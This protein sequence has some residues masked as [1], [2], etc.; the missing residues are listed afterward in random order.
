MLR[1]TVVIVLGVAMAL[2]LSASAD[3]R[4]IIE[5]GPE[6]QDAQKL[7][8]S[9]V[10]RA[11]KLAKDKH[12]DEAAAVLERVARTW[13]ASVHDCNLALAYLRQKAL[14][15]AQLVWDLAALRNGARPKWCTGE[16][17]TQL[18]EAL[19]KEG[20]VPTT[21][22]VVPTDAV[23]EINGIAMRSMRTV[24][25]KPGPAT[26]NATAPGRLAKTVDVTIAAPVAKVTITLEEPQAPPPDAGVP[27]LAPVDAAPMILP[28][29][30][31]PPDAATAVPIETPLTS[32]SLININGKP[33]GRRSI[34]LITAV[35]F[36]VGA[37]IFG[38][39]TYVAKNEANDHYVSD[40]AFTSTKDAY[41]AA[42]WATVGIAGAATIATAVYIYFRATD[43]KPV[44]RPGKL[45]VTGD[46]N[47]FGISY[48]GTFGGDP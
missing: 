27:P 40:P 16:V 41:T 36:W 48:S 1:F 14:T 18:S 24:W 43:D 25:L 5:P 29:V 45:Q 30:A 20:F 19:H 33:V 8:A 44:P 13:P 28:P 26:F 32:S 12:I 37:G 21:I 31:P 39:L 34:A 9:D 6:A 4:W 46:P 22:D 2:G 35:T 38:T 42:A 11:Q 10:Q 47:G 3:E 17:S 15:K 23:V 7:G